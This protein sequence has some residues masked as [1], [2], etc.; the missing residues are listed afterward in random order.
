MIE[1]ISNIITNV[2]MA[3]YQP[4]WFAVILAILLTQ[5]YLMAEEVSI[6]V[7]WEKWKENFIHN[8]KFRHLFYF[9]MYL[10]MAFFRTL[11]NRNMWA[12]PLSDVIGNWW[13]YNDKGELSTESFENLLLFV[14]YIVLVWVNFREKIGWEGFKRCMMQSVRISFLSSLVIE[15]LQL[16]LRI[17]TFQL[18]DLF[19]NTL[20]GL[21]GGLIYWGYEKIKGN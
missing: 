3:A 21:I 11:W 14:P 2:L 15:S 20:G 10:T 6:K 16:L 4:F 8:K 1:I 13:I 19:Y 7:I 12:N 5:I 17:G 18:S 9:F